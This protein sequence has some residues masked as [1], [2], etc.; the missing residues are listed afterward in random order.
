MVKRTIQTPSF[1]FEQSAQQRGFSLVAGMDE[2]GRGA[3]AGPLVAAVVILPIGFTET[4]GINDS[5]LVPAKLRKELTALIKHAALFYAIEEVPLAYINDYGI[6]KAGELAFQNLARAVH[7]HICHPEQSEGSSV[8]E[9]KILRSAQ[10][11]NILDDKLFFLI[12]GFLIKNFDAHRQ[13]AIIKGDQ[14]S[15][16]I[17]AASIIAKVYRD[18]LMEALDKEYPG[19]NFA[20]HKGYGTLEHRQAIK[21][22]GLCDLHRASFDLSRFV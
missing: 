8:V 2:V 1:E 7:S 13:Q 5:K 21:K 12:D 6:G 18:A 9:Y 10:N 16:S 4:A 15:F 20:K 22:H 11:D 14:K 17:A 19:Y 3:F